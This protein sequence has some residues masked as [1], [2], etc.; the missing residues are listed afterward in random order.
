[1]RQ[2]QCDMAV[3]AGTNLTLMPL[4]AVQFM[5]LGMLAMD[6]KSRSFDS[7]GEISLSKLDEVIKFQQVALSAAKE[8]ALSLCK[9]SRLPVECTAL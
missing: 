3:V 4:V 7:E 5:R 6:G 8:S 1:M 2:G 9:G